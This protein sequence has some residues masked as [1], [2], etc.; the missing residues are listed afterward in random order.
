L[1]ATASLYGQSVPAG[2]TACAA[3]P[4]ESNQDHRP[5]RRFGNSARHVA[6][7]RAANQLVAFPN[8]TFGSE[9]PSQKNAPRREGPTRGRAARFG[10]GGKTSAPSLGNGVGAP[11][12]QIGA[13]LLNPGYFH[14]LPKLM[15]LTKVPP[16]PSTWAM[17]LI[18]FAGPGYAGYRRA[19]PS[20]RIIRAEQC[21]IDVAISAWPDPLGGTE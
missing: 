1:S 6:N 17:M 3:Q 14:A 7:A 10:L 16:E 13:I 20:R 21:M 18:G 9:T 8:P 5:G 12:F 19:N 4:R 11:L 2:Q 15:R